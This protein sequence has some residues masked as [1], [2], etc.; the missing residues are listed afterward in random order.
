LPDKALVRTKHHRIEEPGMARCVS[1]GNGRRR[2]GVA[3]ADAQAE[4]HAA[5]IIAQG[6]D[7]TLI[8]ADVRGRH[9]LHGANHGLQVA[10]AADLALEA[11]GA[12]AQGVSSAGGSGFDI[13]GRAP[14]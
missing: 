14:G 1:A 4:F 11:C 9:G 2:G 10:G 8:L 3:K 13:S 12:V 7:R 5:I 6:V